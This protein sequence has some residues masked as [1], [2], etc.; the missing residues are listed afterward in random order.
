MN[1]KKQIT[2]KVR[3]LQDKELDWTMGKKKNV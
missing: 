2:Q 1:S 3:I